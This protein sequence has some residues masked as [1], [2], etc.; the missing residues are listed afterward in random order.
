MFRHLLVHGVG[1][2]EATVVISGAAVFTDAL[3][4]QHALGEALDACEHL[5]IDVGDIEAFDATFRVLLCSLHRR[6]ELVNKRISITGVLLRREDGQAGNARVEG[7]LFK[8]ESGVCTLWDRPAPRGVEGRSDRL[9]RV[10][11]T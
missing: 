1:K 9:K 11:G 5:T 8:D 10:N 6:S 2:G 3:E 4:M 7:C